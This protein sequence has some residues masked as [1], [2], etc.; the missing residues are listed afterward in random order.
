MPLK[1]KQ[2]QFRHTPIYIRHLPDFGFLQKKSYIKMTFDIAFFRKYLYV[3]IRG[4]QIR[5]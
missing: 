1:K 3:F 2:T 4:Q 5:P